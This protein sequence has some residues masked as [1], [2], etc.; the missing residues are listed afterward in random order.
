MSGLPELLND[1]LRMVED[2]SGTF[3][4]NKDGYRFGTYSEKDGK[5][6]FYDSESDSGLLVINVADIENVTRCKGEELEILVKRESGLTNL[7]YKGYP[8]E[9]P[10]AQ[11]VRIIPE[12]HG[13]TFQDMDLL[14][15]LYPN[16]KENVWTDSLTG[17]R[18]IDL[19][20]LNREGGIKMIPDAIVDVQNVLEIESKRYWGAAINFKKTDTMDK[21]NRMAMEN[22]RNSFLEW[23]ESTPESMEP[24]DVITA[25]NLLWT[26][27]ATA[28]GLL[29]MEE[30]KF[31]L[32]ELG[33]SMF[34]AAIER[35]YNPTKV[36][37]A[38][39]L[40]GPQGTGKTTFCEAL[41]GSWYKST[42]QDVHNVKQFME[43]ANGGVIVEFR[44][45]LQILNPET[46]K[47]F[48]DSKSLQYRKPYDRM[49]REYPIRFITIITT[50]DDQPLIDN[51][52]A[53]RM[54]PVYLRGEEEGVKPIE[55][56]EKTIRKIWK[57]ALD[58]YKEGDRWRNHW[59]KIQK[60]AE[61]MQNYATAAPPYYERV[62][63]ALA[64]LP[65]NV[66]IPNDKLI[67]VLVGELGE[68]EAENARR[69]IKKSPQAYKL[70][71]KHS[72]IRGYS[73]IL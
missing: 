33:W 28:P 16:V 68:R 61:I 32:G 24:V 9:S 54:A 14:F 46:L 48:L 6:F 12:R 62:Q 2:P 66:I 21:L 69:H 15:G 22:E 17:N 71:R 25:D 7:E 30:A 63:R 5:I 11:T 34:L 19:R 3:I 23:I 58:R 43:S 59:G 44:E 29:D 38:V 35:Q 72:T 52:G 51:T 64:T 70:E 45:G 37:L 55:I 53:R 50:N 10:E 49:E 26:I 18:F 20:G 41:G 65:D 56:P 8:K 60:Q 73:K 4:E 36:D 1:Y 27:G 40:I 39:C 57:T 67:E 31:Y 13:G 47:D 42:S